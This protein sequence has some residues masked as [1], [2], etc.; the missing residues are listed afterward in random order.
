MYQ[1]I[2]YEMTK[3][4][5]EK[6]LDACKP[7]PCMLIGGFAPAS[8]QE[9]ANRAWAELGERMGFD[10][11]TVQPAPGDGR[12]FTAVP[13]E[14]PEQKE[15]REKRQAEESRQVEIATI[16]SRMADDEARL[17]LLIG[18]QP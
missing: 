17:K 2:N 8:P 7:V 10:S 18:A 12:F 16:K 11:S 15:A 14:T 5:F 4:D 9:N 1:R 3:E 6:I 13:S